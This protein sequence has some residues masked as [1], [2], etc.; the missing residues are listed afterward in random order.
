MSK[1]FKF[2]ISFLNKINSFSCTQDFNKKK[3]ILMKKKYNIKN[4]LRKTFSLSL[5]LFK[6]KNFFI[7][8]FLKKFDPIFISFFFF[9]FVSKLMLGGRKQFVLTFC[10][11]LFF[12]IKFF[13]SLKPLFVFF[14]CLEGS[15]SVMSHIPKNIS[16][17]VHT[18][19]TYIY[20]DKQIKNAIKVFINSV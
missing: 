10:L 15:R 16:G 12:P 14:S 1:K 9:K 17:K 19:P 11:F 4:L 5:R 8:N 7:F 20:F 13:I 6:Y 18:V 3:V 2:F